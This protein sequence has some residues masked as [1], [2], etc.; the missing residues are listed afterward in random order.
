MAIH[1]FY[2]QAPVQ[3]IFWKKVVN[4]IT[5]ETKTKQK[6]PTNN[7]T[8]HINLTVD[9]GLSFERICFPGT[10]ILLQETVIHKYGK[11]VLNLHEMW[12]YCIEQICDYNGFLKMDGGTREAKTLQR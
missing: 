12:R 10:P 4:F 3:Y 9:Q 8:R 2:R 6:R 7:Q 11:H 5:T 1:I